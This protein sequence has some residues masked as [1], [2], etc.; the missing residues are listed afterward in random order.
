M[1]VLFGESFVGRTS[2][3]SIEIVSSFCAILRN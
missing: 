1:V 2:R 3:W